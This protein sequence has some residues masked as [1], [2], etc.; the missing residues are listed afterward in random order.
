MVL[1]RLKKADVNQQNLLIK[2]RKKRTQSAGGRLA[3]NKY[4]FK[5]EDNVMTPDMTK[6]E[7]GC[8][9]PKWNPKCV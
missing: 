6:R 9:Q 3:P 2:C 1:I 8:R 4:P 7:F 5:G